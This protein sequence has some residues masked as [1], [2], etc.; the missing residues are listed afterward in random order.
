MLVRSK[1][2]IDQIGIT[3]LDKFR[4]LIASKLEHDAVFVVVAPA[5][6]GQNITSDFSNNKIAFRDKIDNLRSVLRREQREE[7]FDQLL[8]YRVLTF[9]PPRPTRL[10]RQ[11]PDIIWMD[12]S[13][14]R[15]TIA[16]LQ[17]DERP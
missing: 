14:K 11:T 15:R 3:I 2:A 1:D 7:R 12:G 13:G 10:A 8:A 16:R 5:A 6:L 9:E 4:D 17:R